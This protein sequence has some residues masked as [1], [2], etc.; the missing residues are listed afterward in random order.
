MKINVP[1]QKLQHIVHIADVHI[2][3]F[4]RREEYEQAFR[5]LYADIR[6]KQLEDFIIVLAGDIVHAK[7]DMSPE[8]VD[9][10]SRFLKNIADIAPTILIAGN[11]DCNLANTNRLDALTP[12]VSNLGHPQ[13]HYIKDSALVEVADTTFA[14]CSIFDEV[15]H[16]PTADEIDD[17]YTKVALYH[18][19]VHGALTDAN[20]TITNRHVNVSKFDGFHMTLLGD[21]HKSQ[22]LQE[23][24]PTE[25]KPI[26]R[27]VGSLIQ[28][29]HGESLDNHGWCLWDVPSR[30]FTFEELENDYGYATLEVYNNNITYP[31]RMPKN[32]RVRLFTGDLDQT[33]VKKLIT[34]L[35]TAH[36][37]IE[38]SVNKSR[39]AK[40][41]NRTQT[42]QHDNLDLQNPSTQLSL[43]TD[44]LTRN[45]PGLSTEVLNAIEVINKDMNNKIV[46]DDQSRNIHWRPLKFTFS[47]M[48]SYGEDNEINFTDMQGIYGIFAANASGKS[49]I[50]DALMFCLYDKTP[51]AFKGDHI[52]NNRKDNFECELTFE[53]NNEVFGIK[54][55]GN[56]KKNGDVKVDVSFWKI[57]PN[58]N[59]LNLNGEDRRDTNANI[60]S[61]VGTY[62][63]FIMTALSSQNSNALFIDKSHS[64][65]KDLLIQ[66]MGLNI[67]DKLFD[68]AHDESREIAGV[69]KRF[70]KSDV[71]DQLAETHN[72][73]VAE[74]EQLATIE[75]EK[76]YYENLMQGLTAEYQRQQSE[77]RPVPTTSGNLTELETRLAKLHKQLKLAQED[78]AIGQHTL[79]NCETDLQDSLED[80]EQYDTIALKES[81][82]NWNKLNDLLVKGNSALRIV[83]TKIEEKDK[84]K[85]KLGGYTYN[86]NCEV[87]ISNNLSVIA[88]L[89]TVNVELDELH[90][91]RLIQ[92]DSITQ[93]ID[94]MKPLEIDKEVYEEALIAERDIDTRRAKL[95]QSITTL[96]NANLLLEKTQTSVTSTETEIAVYKTNEENILHNQAIEQALNT[97]QSN[98]NAAK[99]KIQLIDKQLRILH[100]EQSVLQAK[101][102]DLANKLKEAEVLETTYEAFNHYMMAIGRDGIPYELMGKVIPTI[103]AEINNILSQI[104]S[105]TVSLEVDGKNINGKLSYDYDRIWPL[106]NSSG[107]ERFVSSLAIRVAL[108]K[109]SSLPKPS[110]LVIDEGFAT[111]DAEHIHAMQTLFNVLKTH[112]GYILIVSHLDAMRDMVD[113]LIEIKK[114][115]G[116]SSVS[117]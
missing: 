116:F 54:R 46:H 56:R 32:A 24:N 25:N 67:F 9:V 103:E 60:R 36:N 110:F 84:F 96:A 44:W 15:Q 90:T 101:K 63:D 17:K 43:I 42:T 27:F 30:S 33:Q 100:G 48:F 94:R 105:F 7:T 3:L 78:V 106:E 11:H 53:I 107:M 14:V 87:C 73:L 82:D 58:G 22:T 104:V 114:E 40:I 75:S 8:L 31:S 4:H 85:H 45:Y 50:M 68:A 1:F 83:N 29:N 74:Q 113:H 51:R 2:R 91:K 89:G 23:Y 61:Y 38:L 57:Q 111:L 69:L 65:R 117:V 115:D 93:I 41:I 81:V 6:S 99:Q 64:E 52:I 12:I 79:N 70:K 34:T 112:F 98:I 35:R 26:I 59:T 47:N 97:I 5:T 95:Q 13:L 71:T 55:L 62:E 86:P 16:W 72:T 80:F 21:I 77:K 10:T 102:T 39:Y 19:P 49:S 20:F 109:A 108:L 92:E 18:G 88:D 37:I 66:F 28:Q 76:E